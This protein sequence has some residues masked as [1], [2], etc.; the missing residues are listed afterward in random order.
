[1]LKGLRPIGNDAMRDKVEH[2]RE[3]VNVLSRRCDKFGT[4]LPVPA[5]LESILKKE[6]SC[7]ISNQRGS[8]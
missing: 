2:M 6:N 5:T 1:V 4:E 8:S 3:E 7:P